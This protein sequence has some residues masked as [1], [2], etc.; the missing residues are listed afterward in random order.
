LS[1]F[2]LSLRGKWWGKN[3]KHPKVLDLL[4]CWRT[5]GLPKSKIIAVLIAPNI[6]TLVFINSNLRNK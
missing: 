2:N 4:E 1:L 6:H 5:E 3:K